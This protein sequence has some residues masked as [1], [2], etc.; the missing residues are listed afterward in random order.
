MRCFGRAL[1]TFHTFLEEEIAEL[2]PKDM[3]KAV[4]IHLLDEISDLLY[5]ASAELNIT[6]SH[7]ENENFKDYCKALS[8]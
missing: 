2:L 4:R 8:H 3:E 5:G 1:G 7:T 6:Q